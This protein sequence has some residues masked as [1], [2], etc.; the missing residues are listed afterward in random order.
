MRRIQKN[1]AN[2]FTQA[3]RHNISLQPASEITTTKG[4]NPDGILAES[5]AIMATALHSKFGQD[6]LINP[7]YKA[8]NDLLAMKT[9]GFVFFLTFTTAIPP[10]AHS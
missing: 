3:T 2:V 9:S 5:E 8:E 6:G 1:Y 10:D 7:S 4:M